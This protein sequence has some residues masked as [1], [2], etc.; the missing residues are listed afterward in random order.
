MVFNM[1]EMYVG[2]GRDKAVYSYNAERLVNNV[3]TRISQYKPDEVFYIKSIKK[4]LF[5]SGKPKEGTHAAK[6]AENVKIVSKNIY[7]NNKI[8]AFSNETL[9]DFLRARGVKE[10][11]M[12]GV[13]GGLSVG[14]TALTATE[15]LNFHVI[16]NDDCIGTLDNEKKVK[17]F[18]KIRKSRLS[19]ITLS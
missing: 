18:S 5:G 10:I 17:C 8:D 11:E 7:E 6:F 16:I 3:S 4:G 1:Q 13:D 9:T 2:R 15:D 19:Y 14:A 12:V